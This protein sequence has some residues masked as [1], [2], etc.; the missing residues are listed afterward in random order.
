M[1]EITLDNCSREEA[2]S[3]VIRLVRKREFHVETLKDG[4]KITIRTDGEKS[5]HDF[6][7]HVEGEKH[8]LNYLDNFFVDMIKKQ[9]VNQEEVLKILVAMK[10]CTELMPYSEIESL[11]PEL[12]KGL[13]GESVEF[14]AKVMRWLAMREEVNE[15]DRNKGV[16]R[17]GRDKPLNAL[18]EY[19]RKGAALKSVI[20][21]YGLHY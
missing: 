6:V 14:L 18:N 16:I 1:A 15:W 5:E 4:R 17:E 9:T 19:F 12:G 7:V 21:R 11:F 10:Q 20:Q 8:E 3:K 13:P 2:R